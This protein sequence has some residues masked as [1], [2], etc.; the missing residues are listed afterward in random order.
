MQVK[1][2][3]LQKGEGRTSYG[4]FTHD[5]TLCVW[6]TL[7]IIFAMGL[8]AENVSYHRGPKNL[9]FFILNID[10]FSHIALQFID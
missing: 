9:C 5:V 6:R 7:R 2:A 3:F 1:K 8:L 4:P 10:Q